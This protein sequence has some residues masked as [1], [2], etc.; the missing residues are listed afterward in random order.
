MAKWNDR[1]SEDITKSLFLGFVGV[2][3]GD[4]KG[5]GVVMLDLLSKGDSMNEES[6]S[7]WTL[8]ANILQHRNYV[9]GDRNL[10]RNSMRFCE[11][12]MWPPFVIGGV[13][14]PGGCF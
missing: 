4:K 1:H 5:S 6:G 12:F 13:Y 9:Y 11:F 8:A 2:D 14:F 10:S 3:K 7:K